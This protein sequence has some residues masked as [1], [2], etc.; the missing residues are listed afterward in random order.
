MET[1]RRNMFRFAAGASAG[2]VFT[3]APWKLLDDVSIWSQNWG[4]LPRPLRGEITEKLTA[5]TLCPTG[6]EIKASCVAGQPYR[7]TGIGR[8]LCP[9]GIGAHQLPYAA[10]RIRK[11]TLHGDPV[12]LD[13]AAAVIQ[14]RI[15]KAIHIA[16]LDGRPA[17]A[18][19][20]IFRQLAARYPN[21]WHH[22]TTAPDA[23]R[24]IEPSK[25]KIIVSFG[26]PVLHGWQ[27]PV[28]FLRNR[29]NYRLIQIEPAQSRTA[30]FADSWLA[31]RPRTEGVIA[32][33]MAHVILRDSLASDPANYKAAV[34][35][36][37]PDRAEQLT[38]IPA[39]QIEKAAHDFATA[40]G[41]LALAPTAPGSVTPAAAD[42]IAALN[43]LVGD[44]AA[45]AATPTSRP[46]TPVLESLPDHSIDVLFIDAAD[47]LPPAIIRRKLH[48]EAT[49]VALA[50][51]PGEWTVLADI[52][53]PT[54]TVLETREDVP[55]PPYSPRPTFRLT[56][57]ILKPPAE[58][59][60]PADFIAKVAGID[61]TAE[62]AIDNRIA[63]IH[64]AARGAVRDQPLKGISLEDFKTALTEGATW[65]GEPATGRPPGPHLPNT[66]EVLAKALIPE[67]ADGPSLAVGASLPPVP[68]LGKLYQES[69]LYPV[70]GM[71]RMSPDAG[72]ANGQQVQMSTAF[73]SGRA[74][75]K[76]DPSLPLGILQTDADAALE[77][78][79]GQGSAWR[80]A[81]VNLLPTT[82]RSAS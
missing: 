17:R 21:Q 16:I 77:L 12:T 63:A 50:A 39:G 30:A 67:P 32:A 37:A 46:A 64:K 8:A 40:T 52:V 76:L 79:G 3:P 14:E 28:D 72:L 42:M 54:P 15:A 10:S 20:D 1:T 59:T 35:A 73:G 45:I 7:L 33:A 56:A 18:T 9:A 82:E 57:A 22:I 66:P 61:I 34:A 48:K 38:G 5:C 75:V 19:S 11:A 26:E 23:A 6:C 36:F 68:L 43:H 51:F 78:C 69:T 58:T 65:V 31:I 49:V 25:A 4:W 2:I 47:P 29:G 13:K 62:Q 71:V 81:T 44:R 41:A 70:A 53:I 74:T 80:I 27:M 24:A 55:E 60:S